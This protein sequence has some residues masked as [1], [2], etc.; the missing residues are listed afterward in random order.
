M[1]DTAQYKDSESMGEA[2][3]A[4]YPGRFSESIQITLMPDQGWF[5]KTYLLEDGCNK[6]LVLRTRRA[7]AEEQSQYTAG[8]H[9]SPYFKEAWAIQTAHLGVPV[10]AI[11]GNDCGYFYLTPATDAEL[12]RL[13]AFL[14]QEYL[15]YDSAAS[16]IPEANRLG[17]Y[18]HIGMVA[19][20]VNATPVVGFGDT[21]DAM[22]GGFTHDSWYSY[23]ATEAEHFLKQ[24]ERLETLLPATVLDLACKRLLDTAS[25]CQNA[26]LYHLDFIKNWNNI[27]VDEYESITGII[28]WEFAG[29]GPAT[30]CELASTLYI[31]Y[32]DNASKFERRKEF[33]ALLSGYGISLRAYA[34]NFRHDVE[35]LM[36]RHALNALSKYLQLIEVKNLDSQPWRKIHA[37]RAVALLKEILQ[38]KPLTVY[39]PNPSIQSILAA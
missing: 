35:S 17:F 12:P 37:V 11:D 10:A 15:P 34:A 2:L 26:T 5:N 22:T 32:R 23:I 33:N 36:I 14:L 29:A 28:D 1:V 6:P 27:L 20:Q 38:R 39:V 13:Y 24:R 9:W 3:R 30:H 7:T 16:V 8:E 4:L 18:E 25:L 21:F 19:R 31:F